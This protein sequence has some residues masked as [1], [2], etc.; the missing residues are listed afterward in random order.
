MISLTLIVLLFLVW[1]LPGVAAYTM[2]EAKYKGYL[3]L[4]DCFHAILLGTLG[5][6]VFAVVFIGDNFDEIVIWRRKNLEANYE[7]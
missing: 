4:S 1:S 6:L 3:S 7:S 5:G 2:S